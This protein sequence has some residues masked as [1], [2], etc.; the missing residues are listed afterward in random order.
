MARSIHTTRRTLR[1]LSKKEFPEPD[2]KQ[3]ALQEAAESLIRKRRIKKLVLKERHQRIPRPVSTPVTTIPIDVKDENEVVHHGASSDDIRAILNALPEN[4]RL[5]ISRIQLSLGKAYMDEREEETGGKRDPFTGRV[6]SHLFPG[7]FCAEILGLFTIKSGLVSVFA[8]VYDRKQ[9]AL[10]LP[11]CQFYL[12]LH[13]LKTFVHEIAHHHDNIARVAR[14]RWRFD[15]K[16]TVE[17]YAEEMEHKWTQDIVLP[18]LEKHYAKDAK[19]LQNWVA[20]RGGLKVGL[21]FFAGDSRRTRRDGLQKLIFTTSSAFESWLDDLPTCKSLAES[22]LAFAWELHYSDWYEQCLEVLNGILRKSSDWIPALT[23]KADTLVHLQKYDEALL[24][25]RR[26]L[27]VQPTNSDAWET[28]GDVFE[29]KDNWNA[30]LENCAAW[31]RN[32]RLSRRARRE[33]LLH[34]AIAHCALDNI[35]EMEKAIATQL[36]LLPGKPS[37]VQARRRKH[38]YIRVFRRAGKPVPPEFSSETK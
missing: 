33:L 5:G 21:D 16:H 36:S 12:R 38:I 22:R 15:S 4:A 14:G 3:A 31:E 13:A 34:R 25:S 18:Y 28:Q 23:C 9:I 10:P 19:A 20:H 30:L 24:I 8:Y 2:N 27:K 26:I 29:C 6:G 32:G 17:M 7:V 11:L 1:E 35:A 37:D